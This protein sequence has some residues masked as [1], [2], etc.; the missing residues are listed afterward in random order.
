MQTCPNCGA[1][2]APTAKF[3]TKCGTQLS[4]LFIKHIQ[5]LF[6]VY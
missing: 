1:S 4:N 5:M 3:C 2:L 6:Q